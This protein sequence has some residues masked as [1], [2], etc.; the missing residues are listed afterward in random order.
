M[1]IM[2]TFLRSNAAFLGAGVLLTFTSSYG[3]TFFISV[4]SGEIRRE[5]DLTHGE[6]GTLYALSTAASAITMLWAGQLTDRFRARSLC[7]VILPLFALA[8]FGMAA[9]GTV[10]GLAFV[11]FALR[12]GGQGMTSQIATVAMARW[13]VA[14]RGRALSVASIGFAFGEA[15]LP[16]L[17]VAL[18]ALVDWRLLWVFAGALILLAMPALSK[19]L[20]LERTPQAVAASNDVFGMDNR[21][22]ERR[23]V[24]GHFLFWALVPALL[25]P[26]AFVTAFFFHQLHYAETI[27]LDHIGL[28]ALFP[29]YTVVSVGMMLGAG[30]LVDRFGSG[31]LLPVSML[32]MVAAFLT[33]GA[34]GGVWGAAVGLALMAITVGS[35]FA[36]FAALWAEYYGTKHLGSVKAMAAAVM[37][38]GT[39]IGPILT[40]S[41]IDRGIALNWQMFGI[42]IYFGVAAACAAVGV[43]RAQASLSWV[44]DPSDAA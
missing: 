18:L 35:N 24:L 41:L 13:F 37:V 28:V 5:F 25:G 34:A 29:V 38:L 20:R 26:A 8:C 31:K 43:V 30:L 17:F 27:G 32:P 4:F 33:L 7:L 14:T 16:I 15:I 42:A 1:I 36:L 19:L 12:L 23:D 10:L 40:G 3:Q 6:W 21:H 44:G 11:V 22:W 9:V 39:A 2:L